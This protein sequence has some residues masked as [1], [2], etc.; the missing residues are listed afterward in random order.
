MTEP[1]T[2]IH[3]DLFELA[4]VFYKR[5][6]NYYKNEEKSTAVGAGASCCL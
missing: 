2:I 3:P 5:N 1:S 6:E 4:I